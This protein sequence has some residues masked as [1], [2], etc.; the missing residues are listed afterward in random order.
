[1]S[2]PVAIAKPRADNAEA[3]P[4]RWTSLA[5]VALAQLMVA[6]DAT[7][8]SIALPS[9][10]AALRASDADRQWVVTAYTLS[11]G[12]LLLLGG[13]FADYFGRKRTFL[14]G[15]G[16]FALAS[17]VG[18]WA[19]NFGILVAARAMQGAFAALL[20][21]TALSLL[22]VT[23]TETRERAKAFAIYGAI[24]GSGAVAGM[25]LG[26]ILTQYLTWRWCLYVNIP[27][28]VVAAIGG[29]LVLRDSRSAG[30]PGFD[31]LGVVL[32]SGGLVSLVY[33]CTLAT[34]RGWQ[35]S[36]VVALIAASL[37][38]LVMFVV[39]EARAASPLLPLRIVLDRNRGGAYLAVALGLAGMF[40]AFL[41]LTYY[42]QVVLRYSPVQA[43]LAFLPMTAASQAGSWLIAGRLVPR[44][45]A[46]VLMAPGALVAAAGMALLSQL[47]A[48]SSYL[49]LVLPAEVLLG[50]GTS[51]VMVPAFSIG[52]L[53]VDR[54]EAGVAAAT[55]NT[56]QQVGGS[57]GTAVLN[58]IAT[59]AT[60][61]Y[62]AGAHGSM[63]VQALVH[64]YSVATGW[65]VGILVLGAVVSGV[66]INAGRPRPHP[67]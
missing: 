20:A 17:A 8:V 53:G 34:S 14:I 41:F 65:G 28:A 4:R 33:A 10:Q 31:V 61:A 56:A 7:I 45:P 15:L 11:F 16:G 67:A 52:T 3:A 55:V 48:D 47:Q 62:V 23:F 6:L 9:A 39:W 60:A 49:T 27:I 22:A 44:V 38:L 40:G 46:R 42:L 29:W 25:L 21:P 64:G 51:C 66:L 12:G 58:T 43:G 35:S 19:P 32:A 59:S 2:R 5:F 1:M 63:S 54:R 24:A 57:L 50:L 37:A 36:T 13:R 26:G 30:K 18:G